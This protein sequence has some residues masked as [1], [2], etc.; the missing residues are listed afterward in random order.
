MHLFVA[1]NDMKSQS[2]SRLVKNT[3]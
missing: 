2:T 1:N 3:I